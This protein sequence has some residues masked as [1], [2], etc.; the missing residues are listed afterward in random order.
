M[1]HFNPSTLGLAALAGIALVSSAIADVN[2]SWTSIGNV[3]NAADPSTGYG[4][5]NHAYKI[6]T[7][8][9][10]NAQYVAFLNAKGSSNSAGIFSSSMVNITQSGSSGSY[11]YTVGSFNANYPVIRVTWFDAARFSNWL[12]NGQGGGSMETGAYTLNGATTGVILANPGAQVYIPSENEWYKAA[13]YNGAN[14]T[15]SLYPNGQNTITHADANYAAGNLADVGYGKASSYGTFGQGGNAWEWNDAVVGSSRGRRGG[16]FSGNGVFSGLVTDMASSSR[17]DNDPSYESYDSGFRVASVPSSTS[18]LS[19]LTINS[20]TLSPAFAAATISYSASAPNATTSMTVTPTVTDATATIKVN[21]TTVTSGVA[22][23][24]ISLSVG[25]NK[26]TTVVTAQDGTT[27]TTYTV[28][29]TRSVPSTV[30][31]LSGLVLSSGSLSPTFSAAT[32]S[33]TAS[34]PNTSTSVTVTP[35]CTDPAASVTVNGVAVTSG[36]A[37]AGSSLGTSTVN[38]LTLVVTAQDGVTSSSYTV[39]IDNTPYGIWKKNTFTT[40]AAWSDPT[41][42]GDLAT[43]ANDSVS[44]LMK[45]A[46]ALN[47]MT[48]ATG[49]LTTTS[50]QSGYLTLTYGKSKTASGVTYTVQAS[51]SLSSNSWVPAATVLSQIDPTPGGGSYW[52]V[53]VRDNVPYATHPQRFMRLQVAK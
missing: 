33:Y 20:S 50:R 52:L 49:N 34:V 2:M 16:G 6:G 8:E 14:S 31:T 22:S 21:G 17:N 27:T 44:N 25:T 36:V 38:T 35:M 4:S 28:T 19:G 37:S 23:G 7:Y 3:G 18:T 46:M 43:P 48:S 24:A 15:Y 39:T 51:D 30:A 9:V 45:Y 10:T 40:L 13:Y 47:P 41:V 12:G 42:S 32:H 1:K 5:V 53:T 11:T 29:V 26:I